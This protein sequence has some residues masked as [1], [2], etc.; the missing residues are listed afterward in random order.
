VIDGFHAFWNRGPGGELRFPGYAVLVEHA[1]GRCIFDTGYDFD[2]LI[3]VLPFA[4]PP[5][6]RSMRPSSRSRS[7]SAICC[8]VAGRSRL[9]CRRANA[10]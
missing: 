1:D 9:A 10:C 6:G 5:P 2:H 4:A 3:R 7:V 8:A